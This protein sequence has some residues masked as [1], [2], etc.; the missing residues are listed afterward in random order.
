MDSTAGKKRKRMERA[1]TKSSKVRRAESN[2]EVSI[3]EEVLE[4]EAQVLESRKH[5]NN[6]PKLLSLAKVGDL[7]T[8]DTILPAVALCRIFCRLFANESLSKSKVGG[9]DPEAVI[10][11]WLGERLNEYARLLA[12]TIR[13]GEAEE[14][15]S[16][17]LTLA[18]RLAKEEF[19]QEG[20][21]ELRL[22]MIAQ[23]VDAILAAEGEGEP[24]REE[25]CEKY[26]TQF[27]DVRVFTVAWLTERFKLGLTGHNAE[28]A[29]EILSEIEVPVE[30]DEQIKY[31][32]QEPAKDVRN[33]VTSRKQ[34]KH[35]QTAW[36]A[37]LRS[38][39]TLTKQQH[40]QILGMMVD[41]I[42][43]WFN[44]VELLMDYLT[45]SF[46]VGGATSLLSLSGLFHLMQERNLDYPSFYEKLYSLLDDD[47]LHSKHRSRFFRLLDI[48]MGSTH[49]PAALVASFI[50]RLSRLALHAPPAGI[51]VAVPWIYNMFKQHPQ[52]TFM[53]HRRPL[54]S[55]QSLS[56]EEQGFVDPF[57]PSE[58]D[59]IET[60][61]IESSI[62]EI[63]TL[64]SHWH[65]N[66]ATLAKIISEQFTKQNYNLEDFLDHSYN[67]LLEAELGK[68]TKKTPVVEWEIPKHVFVA[69][70]GEGLNEFGSLMERVLE[71]SS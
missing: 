60:G 7:V 28:T 16:T 39:L 62:W 24:L 71:A 13:E 59:P 68:E 4:L 52:C 47:L 48:F 49:L 32:A 38:P 26:F 69:E 27:D 43:P 8:S 19:S 41:R 55:T 70:D 53:I 20:P 37:V 56:W 67:S 51:V 58:A 15:R 57:N 65:P 42:V 1:T 5:Y 61:A 10:T 45:D 64:Q 33:M 18:M 11:R 17:A 14:V 63:D 46:N 44:K 35:V 54:T 30:G 9:D 2:D 12:D 22:S 36:L 23:V 29:L 6:I 25:F 31:F 3:Q 21:R 50:K 34:R 66:V 40:K